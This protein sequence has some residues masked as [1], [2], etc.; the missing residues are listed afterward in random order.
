MNYK[1]LYCIRLLLIIATCSCSNDKSNSTAPVAPIILNRGINFGDALEA[2]IEGSVNE[3]GFQGVTILAEYFPL[4]KSA[5]F[6]FVRVPIKWSAH[7]GTGSP[8]TIEAS[9]FDRI[10]WVINN[11]FSNNLKVIIDVHH[12]REL[13][14]EPEAH[15]ERFL[16]IWQQI[17]D[18]Y[19][20]YTGDLVFEL[21]NEPNT[22]LNDSLWN[23]YLN[24]AI[25]II[26]LTNPDRV[27]IAGPT[28]WNSIFALETLELPDDNNIIVTIHYYF[29]LP[30]THQGAWWVSGS[31]DWLGTTWEGTDS[32]KNAVINDLNSASAWA[33]KNNRFLFLGEFGAYEKADL[34]SRVRWTSFL[35]REAEKRG[36]SWAYWEFCAGFGIY[37]S[38]TSQWREELLNALIPE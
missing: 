18:H 22:A 36:F 6:D 2:D 17:S 20:D 1:I 5:G 30:F 3:G 24:E 34:A 10:D 13:M 38:N 15:K 27:I 31:D 26:R 28:F 4:I 35:A 23:T 33:E 11:A 21:C 32:E 7:A 14:A 19:K 25:D 9:F 8:Y 37:D 16:A 29:P 12:Y